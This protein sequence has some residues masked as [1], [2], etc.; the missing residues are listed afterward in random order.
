MFLAW[1][2]C[3]LVLNDLVWY[4]WG[5]VR[6]KLVFFVW[7]G[8]L[9]CGLGWFLNL[10]VLTDVLL[11]GLGV[12]WLW[13]IWCDIIEGSLRLSCFVFCVIS[14]LLVWFGVICI[15]FG[16]S[17]CLMV[18]FGCDLFIN[19][20]AWCCWCQVMSYLVLLLLWFGVFSCGLVWFLYF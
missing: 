3:D 5:H 17:Q 9:L 15:F 14:C 8:V 16:G 18:S 11:C 20:L 10:F 6:S 13:M 1:F 7:F 19:D 12:I 2:E 4:Y